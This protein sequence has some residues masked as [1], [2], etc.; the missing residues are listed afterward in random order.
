MRGKIRHRDAGGYS[1][2]I[3]PEGRSELTKD[4][5][6][7]FFGST[8]LDSDQLDDF[9]EFQFR[10]MSHTRNLTIKLV[11]DSP[12]PSTWVDMEFDAEFVPNDYSPVR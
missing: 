6:V 8:P 2:K 7:P 4:Y 9:G 3:T 10:V 11:N 12:Y 5:V 1:V